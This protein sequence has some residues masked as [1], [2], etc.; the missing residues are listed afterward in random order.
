MRVVTDNCSNFSKAFGGI[1]FKVDESRD[2]EFLSI[3]KDIRMEAK[4]YTFESEA[5]PE[6]CKEAMKDNQRE[7]QN[8]D[9]LKSI[10]EEQD[11]GLQKQEKCKSHVL[12]L[13]C[14]QD[15]KSVI[16]PDHH[17]RLHDS[18]FA[19]ATALW[20]ECNRPKS[21]E[22]TT[23]VLGKRLVTP[24]ITRWNSL[25]DSLKSLL[26]FSLNLINDSLKKLKLAVFNDDELAFLNEYCKV[27]APIAA[28]I[29]KWKEEANCYYGFAIPVIRQ[30]RGDLQKIAAMDL[31]YNFPLV[32]GAIAGIEKRLKSLLEQ[33][34]DVT[35]ALIATASHPFFKL[36]PIVKKRRGEIKQKLIE[37]A[38]KHALASGHNFTK[39]EVRDGYFDFESDDETDMKS[40]SDN[41]D[42]QSKASIQ[43]LKFLD[44][45]D[46]SIGLLQ[47]YPIVKEVFLKFNTPLVSS[48]PVEKLFSFGSISLGGRR[49]S[50]SDQDFGKLALIEA[51]MKD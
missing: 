6:I 7:S 2:G 11:P 38:Q 4:P 19:K 17:K 18:A 25:Y 22:L 45:P 14:T 9:A 30:V 47:R 51:N 46:K 48:A 35:D 15:M 49:E 3:T 5:D 12:S 8:D 42:K 26:E 16:Y 37:E 39:Q 36:K 21:L 28:A 23:E 1:G 40:Q 44:D 41:A 27:L 34:D 32:E 43:V 33:S 31:K 24:C 10:P 20:N 50:L 29:D 13:V